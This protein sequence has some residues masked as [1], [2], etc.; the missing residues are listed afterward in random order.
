MGVIDEKDSSLGELRRLA[1]TL[2]GLGEAVGSLSPDLDWDA[3]HEPGESPSGPGLQEK[4]AVL[5]EALSRPDVGIT[6]QLSPFAATGHGYALADRTLGVQSGEARAGLEELAELGLL[7]R[8]L[9]NRVHVCPKCSRCQLNFRETC[10]NCDSLLLRIERLIHH[11]ACAYIGL[12]TEFA[13]GLEMICPKCRQRLFQIGQDFDRPHETYVC[14]GCKEMSELP[15]VHGQCLHCTNL[16]PVL[17][18]RVLDIHTY[19]ATDL[20]ARAIELGRLTGLQVADLLFDP[21]AR[22]ARFDYLL[23]EARREFLRL[24]RHEGVLTLARLQFLVRGEPFAWFQLAPEHEIKD[25]GRRLTAAL[26]E[27]DLAA[28]S[29]AATLCLLLP[30][31]PEAGARLLAQRIDEV[32]GHLDL[33]SPDG[34]P[35][36]GI[37]TFQSWREAPADLEAAV[38][39]LRGS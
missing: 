30:E 33:Q 28:P 24:Q 8:E 22:L 26:R 29:D 39:A 16:F 11:F 21:K 23:L 31:T 10:P 25:L 34:E 27:L 36:S 4:L 19:F 20:T 18:A 35:V 6:P 37:W 2:D 3:S 5:R 13:N 1:S 15:A 38:E 9:H 7:R 32:L 14:D 17:E 12:E